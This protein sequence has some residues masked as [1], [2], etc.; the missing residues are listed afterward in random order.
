MSLHRKIAPDLGPLTTEIV[1]EIDRD[2]HTLLYMLDLHREK[3]SPMDL[4]TMLYVNT[5][6]TEDDFPQNPTELSNAFLRRLWLCNPQ[7][8]STYCKVPVGD[9]SLDMDENSQCAINP[10]DLVAVI[11]MTTNSF[12][13][14]E[15]TH[16]ML[17]C[18]FAVPLYLPPVYPE[19]KGTM[20]LYPFRGV[21]GQWKS[22]SEGTI[23]KN[24]ANSR[25][26][27]LS[28]V[29]LGRCSVS[30]SRVLNRVLGSPH[31][32]NECFI[33]CGMDGG[34]LPR[35][36][37]D[38]L[39]EMCWNL[40]SG[41][42]HYNVFSRPVLVANLRGDAANCE[43]QMSLLCYASA[44]LIVFCGSFGAKERELLASW[45]EN[46]SHMI[47]IDCSTSVEDGQENHN[48]KIKQRLVKDLELPE[49]TMLNGYEGNEEEIAEI[50]RDV[51]DRFIPYLHTAN[52]VGTAGMASDLD[53][54]VDEDEI[55]R[56]AFGEVEEVLSGIEDGMTSYLE[57]QLPLQGVVWKQLCQME[58]EEGRHQQHTTQSLRAE[59]ENLIKQLLD[60]KLTTAMRAFIAAL[61]SFDT[62]KRAFFLSWMR[63]KLEVEQLDK[64]SHLRGTNEEWM[65]EPCIGL[66]HFLREMGLVY[67]RYFRGPNSDLYD[68]F[69]LPYV[70]A[71]LL[72]YGVPLELYD[73]DASVFPMKWVYSVL[74]EVY[75]QLPKFS[76]LRVLTILGFHNSKNAEILSA[77]FSANFPKWGR[78]HIK[79]AYMLLLSL[80]DNLRM[81]M[82]C[83]FLML[84]DT[85]GLNRQAGG[86]LVHDIE[87]ATFVSGLSDITLVDLP[88]EGQD[89]ARSNLQIAVSVLLSTQNLE[90][91]TTFKVASEDAGMDGKILSYVIDVL[92]TGEIPNK[93]QKE[94]L[95]TSETGGV[96]HNLSSSWTS[97]SVTSQNDQINS[98][99]VLRLKKSLLKMFHE[100][101]IN[102]QPTCLGALMEY[103]C[104]LWEKVKN[105][106][107]A[108]KFG[109]TGAADAIIGLCTKLV[110]G[111][112]QLNDQLDLWVQ[113]LDNHITE[114]KESALQNGQGMDSDGILTILRNEATTQ[115]STERDQIKASLW[116]Y[117]R[118]EDID[119]ALVENY[120]G[121]LLKRVDLIQEQMTSDVSQK[122]E[123][124]TIRH[125]MT[126]KMHALLTSLEAALEVRLR[127]LLQTYKNNDSVIEDKEL[128]REFVSVWE[129][130]PSNMKEPPQETQEILARMM[131]QLKKNLSNRGLKKQNVRLRNANQLNGFKVKTSHFALNSKMKKTLKYNKNVAQRFTNNLIEDCDKRV[132]EKL[133]HKE[134]YSD[135]YMRE[136]LA[137]VDKGLE[138]LKG[139]SFMMNP[140]FEADIKGYIC[141]KA[142]VSFQEV[143]QLLIRERETKE[144]FLN[145]T[146]DRHMLNFIYQFRKRHQCQKAAQS[147]TNL[148]LKPTAED[149]IYSSLER[150]IFD[151]ML[152]NKNARL[153]SSPKKF[154]YGLLKEMLLKD[155]FENF[156]EY[157]QSHESF[158]RKSIENFIRAHLSGSVMIEDRREQR[159]H[160]IFDWVKRSIKQESESSSGAQS[161]VRLLLEKVCIS[162]ESLG[163]ITMPTQILEE[164]LF[165]ISTHRE[166]FLADLQESVSVL[167][168]SI[169]QEF[170]EN[171]D[172][173]EVPDDLPNKLEDMLYDRV[174][175]CDK[176]CPFCKA[177]CDLEEKEHNVHEAVVHRPKGLVCYTNANST[178]LSH[179]TCSA[180]I[181]GQNQFQ[182]RH[183]GGQSLP[184]K[185]YRSIYP[186][187][188]IYPEDS[189]NNGAAVYWRYVFMKHNSRFAKEYQCAPAV[190]PEA[191]GKITKEEAL[192]SLREAFHIT[193]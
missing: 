64:L 34:Q 8:R 21:L 23:M 179:N 108:I 156:H 137:I 22:P 161:N 177:P 119:I 84:I 17:Q 149:F 72:L 96:S 104:N 43:K 134:C 132:S 18:N 70:G 54:N 41:D 91:K 166:H 136:L 102:G 27:F 2:K 3:V 12:L 93:S 25:M 73:G 49:G 157:L 36:L 159:M 86:N 163:K 50:L 4:T 182:N 97:N 150:Q 129:N 141:S 124:A 153:Y 133:N 14:Q 80:P 178:T 68:M 10:L 29:R 189:R 92:T 191:W 125:E 85:E 55:C 48:E 59:K 60:Y 32:L 94:T 31:K 183:T 144:R 98:D 11:Y 42:H 9:Y 170:M 172:V 110:Q 120:K 135:S 82:D 101:A 40:P 169:A 24:M 138:V 113:G 76:R 160:Q 146:K 28:A 83:E 181:V 158:S 71:E 112:K 184:F 79:G 30:K 185:E 127:S 105:E 186:D 39:V 58:K 87:L 26:P 53:I 171:E 75:K 38:G 176:R 167:S 162:L 190:L 168:S 188:N 192:Q 6:S 20:L 193:E 115:I 117:L 126:I 165:D 62:T 140:K 139:E 16:R 109:D 173:I 145:E 56:M 52:L 118:Q 81:E 131:E 175:G 57:N 174:K 148:C 69:R 61:C 180:D 123:S 67:E 15:I 151:D 45:R 122:L 147:F 111:E 155:S 142:L 114:L 51:L 33:N 106:N 46:T 89:E 164:P 74:Y 154:H 116:D 152:Q 19:K 37:S 66:E 130:I 121:S 1:S 35:V 95:L 63:V 90:R 88:T 128:E 7:A 187:W 100:K 143:Q 47:I 78:R 5:P 65:Q 77:M 103:M 107:F 99:A 13:Q 44:V